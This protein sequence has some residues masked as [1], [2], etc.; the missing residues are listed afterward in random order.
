M[1]DAPSVLVKPG[2]PKGPL[3]VPRQADSQGGRCRS[4]RSM[5]L[6]NGDG[7]KICPKFWG[8]MCIGNY[9]NFDHLYCMLLYVYILCKKC[10]KRYPVVFAGSVILSAPASGK[11][12]FGNIDRPGDEVTIFRV[13]R[14]V[15]LPGEAE[16]LGRS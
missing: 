11:K 3:L 10:K 12:R 13:D 9:H 14:F 6:P 4:V 1:Q 2:E 16:A 7:K 5:A 8:T 15:F